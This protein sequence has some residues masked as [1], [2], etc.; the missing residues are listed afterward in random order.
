MVQNLMLIDNQKI[1]HIC[2]YQNYTLCGRM[3][4]GKADTVHPL[5]HPT[6]QKLC[7]FFIKIYIY[8]IYNTMS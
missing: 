3:N 4:G 5:T 7:E 2:L 1:L 6:S 8:N